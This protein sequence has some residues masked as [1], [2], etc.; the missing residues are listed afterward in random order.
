MYI[1]NETKMKK[2]TMIKAAKTH[3]SKI[4]AYKIHKF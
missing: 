3:D 2:V 4:N 1:Q